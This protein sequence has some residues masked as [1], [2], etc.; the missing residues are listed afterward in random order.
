LTFGVGSDLSCWAEI[1]I[2]IVLVSDGLIHGAKVVI[3]HLVH[4]MNVVA[5]NFD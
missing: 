4:S 5:L 2:C 1:G 3:S